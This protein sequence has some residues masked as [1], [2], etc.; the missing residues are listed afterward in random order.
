ML[1]KINKKLI[2]ILLLAFVLRL[3]RINNPVAD[4]HAFRQADTASVTR[5]YVK[6]SKIDILRP[7]YHDLSNIQSGLEN[8]D[9]YRM[10]E[11]PFI[12][13]GI[14]SILKVFP[15]WDLVLFS[16]LTSVFAS[17]GTII[18]LYFLVKEISDKKTA[19]LTALIYAVLPYSIYYS[20]VILPE[21]Y[22]LFFST[23]SIWRFLTYLKNKKISAYLLSALALALAALLKPFV[24]FLAPVYLTLIWQNG[25]FKQ[26][27]NWKLYLYP[28]LAFLPLLAWRNW[29]LNFPTGIP[30]SDWLLN[31]NQ[32]RLR[33]AWFRWLFYERLGKLFLGYFGLLLLIANL[34]SK[35]K[36][37]FV[38]AAWWF[39]VILYFIVFATGN[40]QHDY[41]QNIMLPILAISLARGFIF[42]KNKFKKFGKYL[43]TS[44]LL[45]TLIFSWKEIKGY[46]N[47]NHWEYVKAGEAVAKLTEKDAK[48]IAP[49]MGDTIFLF[50]T[51]RR[52]WP[53]GF[54]IEDK[55]TKGAEIYVSSSYDYEARDLEEEYETIE[56]TNDYIIIDL[57]KPL[58]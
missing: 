31:G 19:E 39:G 21:P 51:E 56:K 46:F 23:L 33:P 12:N 7:K 17:L 9:G 4:W 27:K 45:L 20:R 30:A 32:I 13:A 15:S 50:Q 1:K 2:L 48:V 8:P 42:I 43:A 25:A 53:I 54:H 55:I 29:I 5:E 47:V 16:R 38:Y 37:Q 10:V 34:W 24:I 28:F 11:F 49:A 6:A 40:V 14:A 57:R 36:D 52:G 35:K 44:L 3:Y 18:C 41:Y 22:F 26:L 58:E